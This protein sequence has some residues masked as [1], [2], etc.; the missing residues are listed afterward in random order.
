M[1]EEKKELSL[2][3][4]KLNSDLPIHHFS[5]RA[6]ATVLEVFIAH[7]D[8]TYSAQAANAA[9][10]EVDKLEQLLSRYV[11]FSDVSRINNAPADQ[12]VRLEIPS[13]ECIQQA[14]RMSDE[15]DGAFDVTVGLLVDCW[16]DK[17]T[18]TLK[19]P[20]DEQLRKVL[21]HTGTNILKLNEDDFSVELSN[22]PVKIDL[23]GI[24]KGFA[25]DKMVE[26]F[27][28]WEITSALITGG[29]STVRALDAPPGS[30]GW[31][32]TVSNPA[33]PG[34]VLQRTTLIDCSLSGSGLKRGPHIIDPR[35]GHPTKASV[36]AWALTPNAA[37]AD[38]L[39]TAFMIMTETQIEDYCKTHPDTA[40]MTI[41]DTKPNPLNKTPTKTFGPWPKNIDQ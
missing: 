27:E 24:G 32:I 16:L 1:T 11:S 9:F 37:A 36:A 26:T 14:V 31:T 21:E 13:F 34:Q 25:V 38:A 5:K 15:T 2:L 8:A 41:S 4:D 17:E 29:A 33:P 28:F 19:K 7:E 22:S 39:S 35:T 12:P 3:A 20:S 18:E 10:D 6:M 23:G 30:E 40:A